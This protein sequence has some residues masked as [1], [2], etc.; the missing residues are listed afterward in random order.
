LDVPKINCLLVPKVIDFVQTPVV[1]VNVTY[2]DPAHNINFEDT[3]VFTD[4]TSQTFSFQV[5]AASP[6]TYNAAVTYYLAN[7]QV[8][9]RP[10]EATDKT[11]LVIQRYIPTN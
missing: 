2:S 8:V 7:G 10:A 5:D 3:L 6:R 4:P 1:E 11:K 9:A